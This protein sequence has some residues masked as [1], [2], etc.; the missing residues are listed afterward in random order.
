[1]WFVVREETNPEF[2]PAD[3]GD[4]KDTY[5]RYT[6]GLLALPL[7]FVAL[8]T[9][10]PIVHTLTHTTGRI[11]VVTKEGVA[12]ISPYLPDPPVFAA[13]PEFTQMFLH[14]RTISSCAHACSTLE[15]RSVACHGS[16][17]YFVLS[18][19]RVVFVQ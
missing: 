17:C 5:Y 2:L 15:G 10:D 3:R 8:H 13:G 14:K 18:C 11:E 7:H 12:P 19:C 16:R 4:R 1:V 9:N 6:D